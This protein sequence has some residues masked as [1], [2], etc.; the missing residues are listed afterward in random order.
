MKLPVLFT[1]AAATLAAA[2]FPR[3][4]I[5][6]GSVRAILY[7]PDAQQGYYRATRF[8]WSGQI[9]SLEF[10]GHQYFGQWFDRYDPQIHDAIMGPVEEFRTGDAGLG[11]AQAPVG[12]TFVRIGV[13]VVRKP[14]EESYQPFKTY[15]IVDH[16]K[17]RVERSSDRVT[18]THEL[19]T[20]TGYAYVY[21][22]TVRLEPGKPVL[23]IEHS[24]RNTGTLAIETSQYNHN[25]FVMD[26]QPSGP[27][28][29]VSFPFEL[30]GVGELRGPAEIQG[31]QIAIL[32]PLVPNESVYTQ[33]TGFTGAPGEYAI[34]VENRRSGARA[35][36]TGDRPLSKL[37]F[38]SSPKTVCPEP[39]IDMLIAPGAE[40]KW[41][42]TYEFR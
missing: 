1:L 23:V 12:G 37:V 34:T 3:A 4:E 13:G 42:L 35:R 10:Q 27:D 21:R 26:G 24:L 20:K 8:D 30:R 19:S 16:G 36:I 28:Y 38:W 15:D 22:K 2:G 33:L 39:Y 31:R 5:S 41:K 6:N 7:L 40:F 11:Y 18:F 9:A 29:L 14:S 32:K 17:W 25:F